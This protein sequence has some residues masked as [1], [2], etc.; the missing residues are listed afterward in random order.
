MPLR[1]AKLT[2]IYYLQQS[3]SLGIDSGSRTAA[4]AGLST[5]TTATDAT[6]DTLTVDRGFHYREG[7]NGPATSV[8]VVQPD[9]GALAAFTAD[10]PVVFEPVNGAGDAL[11]GAHEVVVR[12]LLSGPPAS[13]N[14]FNG[15]APLGPGSVVAADLGRRRLRQR[16]I[17]VFRRHA[18]VRSVGRRRQPRHGRRAGALAW[19]PRATEN[20][21][22]ENRLRSPSPRTRH[23][24][25]STSVMLGG[26]QT[27]ISGVRLA[28]CQHG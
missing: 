19:R 6:P 12:L 5:R 7:S 3:T 18:E 27:L 1:S 21:P 22:R 23:L 24:N 20:H 8:G 28:R 4:A 17:H 14:A 16:R 13:L 11:G 15:V 10:Q 26:R 25:L 2:I 9:G